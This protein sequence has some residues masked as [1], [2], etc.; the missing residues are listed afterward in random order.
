MCP[1]STYMFE[2]FIQILSSFHPEVKDACSKEDSSAKTV[3]VAQQVLS[4]A[5]LADRLGLLNDEVW[6]KAKDDSVHEEHQQADAFLVQHWVVFVISRH[7]GYRGM[8]NNLTVG[9]S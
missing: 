1:R 9:V 6:N 4:E 3:T 5:F 7:G 2:V 8:R